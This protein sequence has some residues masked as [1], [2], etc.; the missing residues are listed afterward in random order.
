MELDDIPGYTV[1]G[2]IGA[3]GTAE[4]FLA[5]RLA[6]AGTKKRVALKRILPG[7]AQDPMF[8]ELFEHEARVAMRLG[9]KNIVAVY[10]FIEAAGSYVLVMEY[11]EGCDLRTLVA[12]QPLDLGS[13]LFVISEVL[14]GLDYAHRREADDGTALEI[15]HR[16]VTPS[17]ILLSREG[18]VKLADFGLARSRDRIGKSA[19]GVK[20]TFAFMA[21]E[22][23]E[24]GPIDR[25]TDLFSV[26]ATLYAALSGRS[27]FEADGPLATLERVRAIKYEPLGIAAID[28]LLRRVLQREVT[29]RF[30]DAGAM[31]AAV[32]E[33]AQKSGV[34][35]QA[36]S[37]R[38]RVSA[39]PLRVVK[40]SIAAP[41]EVAGTALAP[42]IP[43]DRAARHTQVVPKKRR[44]VSMMPWLALAS[45]AL[46]A[47]AFEL[48]RVFH[49]P[50]AVPIGSPAAPLPEATEPALPHDAATPAATALAPK[51]EKA[52]ERP[53]Y[54]T[55]SADPWAYVFVDGRRRGTTPLA[56]LE[57]S[58]GTHEVTFENP[59]LG[60]SR[61]QSI[62][63][64]AGEHRVLSEKLAENR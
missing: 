34:V 31:L 59:A 14:R 29:A 13:A 12:E 51:R 53:A 3:G 60:A 46:V 37:L 41:L 24:S 20:G 49:V 56:D 39:R 27:P 19:V 54:L 42:V 5:D 44:K 23:A 58:P 22:Q 11:V 33:L 6:V 1:L 62:R 4:L 50:R 7:F 26:G 18:E 45:L 35:L 48:W 40:K 21:P 52:R 63:L 9:H 64:G 55:V 8:R 36:E 38:Q 16:D 57:L 28:A 17:N 43:I 25:R 61:T 10:D 30:A 32:E 2:S 47:S 15:V